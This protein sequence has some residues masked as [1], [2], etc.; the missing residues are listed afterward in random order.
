T[1]LWRAIKKRAPHIE[2]GVVAS[3]RNADIIRSDKDVARV[4]R[5][6]PYNAKLYKAQLKEVRTHNYDVAFLCK[7][8][9]LAHGALIARRSTKNGLTVGITTDHHVRHDL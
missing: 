9:K 7:I 4:H 5:V 6:D 2:I 3:F 8:D 1:P